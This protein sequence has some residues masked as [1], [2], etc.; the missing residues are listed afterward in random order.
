MRSGASIVCISSTAAK[1]TFR[2]LAAYHVAKA[3]LEGLVRAAAEELGANGTR[4]NAVRPGLTCSNATGAMFDA[5]GMT[6]LFLRVFPLARLGEPQVI[7]HAVRYLAGPESSWV[8]GQ[9]FAVGWWQRAAQEPRPHAA[10]GV[11]TNNPRRRNVMRIVPPRPFAR[12]PW[13]RRSPRC[14]ATPRR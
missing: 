3:G 11:D 10:R 13:P 12:P 2:H 6:E 14:A 9:S 5:L 1:I 8:T 7:A 4:V